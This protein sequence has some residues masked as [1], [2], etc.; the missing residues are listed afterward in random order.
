MKKV[1][2]VGIEISRARAFQGQ[3]GAIVNAC[4][5]GWLGML[6]RTGKMARVI[7]TELALE[8]NLRR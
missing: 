5:E 6:L 4:V 1:K 7:R 2:A 8:K 3:G